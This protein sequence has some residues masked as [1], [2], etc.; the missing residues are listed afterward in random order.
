[1]PGGARRGSG[2]KPKPIE[3][4]RALGNP[5]KRRLPSG[6]ELAVV[7]PVE[8]GPLDL[9]A[10]EIFDRTLAEGI[11]WLGRTEGPALVLLREMLEERQ[12]LR[13]AVLAGTGDRKQLR[14]IEKMIWSAYAELGFTAASRSRLGLAEVK[15]ASKLEALRDRQANRV[16]P[17]VAHKDDPS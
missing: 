6:A 14:D 8:R 12:S 16:A 17:K 4:K 3:M 5:G 15:A 13:D 2:R 7:A 11:V 9:R 10:D 1:M